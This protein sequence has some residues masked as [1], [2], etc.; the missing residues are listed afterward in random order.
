[1]SPTERYKMLFYKQHLVD[2]NLEKQKREAEKSV[3]KT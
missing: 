3:K 2:E 1:M